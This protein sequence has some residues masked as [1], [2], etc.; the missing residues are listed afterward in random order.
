MHSSFRKVTKCTLLVLMVL[1]FGMVLLCKPYD[2]KAYESTNLGTVARLHQ[3]GA[4]NNTISIEWEPAANATAYQISYKINFDKEEYLAGA[5]P[6]TQFTLSNLKS[7]TEY[8]IKVTPLKGSENGYYSNC[9]AITLPDKLYGLAQ[10]KWWYWAKSL[11]VVWEE[12]TAADGYEV[13]FFDD[14]NKMLEHKDTAVSRVSFSNI[15]DKVYTVKVRSYV[16]YN[17][18]KYYSKWA[19]IKCLNQARIKSANVKNNKLVLKWGKVGGA[20]GYQVFVSTKKKSGYKKVATVNSKKSSCTIKKFRGK[21]FS[22]KKTYYVYVKTVCN[23]GKSKNT[24]GALYY[25]NTR[26]NSFGYLV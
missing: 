24:S 25:W 18:Y 1:T 12:Q 23:K 16:T 15:K 22:S 14:K 5:T 21:K 2:A 20:T 10:E 19:S 8:Y 7:C 6:N 11:D 26:N 3:V 17:N 9:T 13:Q 4:T